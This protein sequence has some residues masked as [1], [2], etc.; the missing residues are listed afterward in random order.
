[1]TSDMQSKTPNILRQERFWGKRARSWDHGAGNNPGL[2]KVVD[3]VIASASLNEDSVV[4]DLG[5]GSG[6]LSLR[7]AP[8]VKK[9]IAVDISQNMIN[10]LVKNAEANKITNIETMVAPIEHLV[11]PA[12]SFDVIV[13][14]YALHHLKDK[15]KALAVEKSFFWLAD[16]GQIVIGDMMFGR[17]KDVRD[18]QIIG[19]KLALMLKRGPAGWWRI[20][21]NAFRYLFR[22]YERPVSTTAWQSML[23]KAGFIDIACMEVI[24]E[25]AVVSGLKKK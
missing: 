5:C 12:A 3:Q 24:N 25:A 13:T 7:I 9:V 16:G 23:K 11:L 8:Y 1:M 17:G 2:V 4:M 21:K 6:Q 18:R 22:F 15:D 14:N 19:S 10:L 20:A